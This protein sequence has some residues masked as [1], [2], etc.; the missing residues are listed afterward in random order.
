MSASA[1]ETYFTRGNIVDRFFIGGARL[2]SERFLRHSLPGATVSSSIYTPMPRVRL[3]GV[4]EEK[5]AKIMSESLLARR[6]DIARARMK[7][8]VRRFA[9]ALRSD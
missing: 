6:A 3:G 1:A 5:D 9:R 4:Y 2:N 8:Q 7:K